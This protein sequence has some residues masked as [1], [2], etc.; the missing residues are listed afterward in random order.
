MSSRNYAELGK[1]IE[2]IL[3]RL[4]NNDD[5]MKLLYYVDN[6]PLSK[7]SISKEVINKEILGELIK[8]IPKLKLDELK[9]LKPHLV[10][11]IENGR[12]NNE[13]QEFTDITLYFDLIVPLN[14]WSIKTGNLRPFLILGEIQKSLNGKTVNGFGRLQDGGFNLELITDEL[15]IYNLVYRITSF[16]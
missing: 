13:N 16:D 8:I 3:D 11:R 2:A 12:I 4:I 5:L 14:E 1:Y 15:S 6:N 7:P 9:V 10:L